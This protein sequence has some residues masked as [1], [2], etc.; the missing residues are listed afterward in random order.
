M[1][2]FRLYKNE[3]LAFFVCFLICYVVS[4]VS[5]TLLLHKYRES[6]VQNNAFVINHL[7]EAHPEL[8]YEIMSSFQDMKNNPDLSVVSKYGFLED[9]A[10]SSLF[11]VSK[12]EKQVKHILFCSFFFCFLLFFSIVFFFYLRREKRISE[13]QSFLFKVLKNDYEINFKDYRED[14][15]SDL[16]TDLL[17]VT[18]KLRT[19]SEISL[20]DKKNLERTLSDI[21]HQ[22]RTP[23]TSLTI[24]NDALMDPKLSEEM[25]LT[26]LNQQ[27]EQLKRMDWL[28]VALLK[29]SQI[30][31]GTIVFVKKNVEIQKII[32]EA[33]KPLMIPME[34]K[35]IHYSIDVPFALMCPLDFH[36]TVEAI[37]NLLKNALEHTKEKGKISVIAKDNPM[38]VEIVI[39]DNGCG[40]SKEDLAHIFERFYKGKTKSDSIGIGLNLTKS[41]I[42]K[43][44]GTINVESHMGKGTKFIIHFY[45]VT[46]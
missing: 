4:F 10:V 31:S 38:Y 24:T 37:G 32:E 20:Q 28:I 14:C 34:L 41:I 25:R 11:S 15:L 44:D 3:L 1:K 45:K 22:L 42:E 2:F 9:E 23:L 21:S 33:F 29:M 39:E 35:Q 46:V 7:I 36:W 43:Q 12:M 30:D 26:F 5:C 16:K 40:I 6:Y 18:N 17:K 13:I 8:E 27:K 19:V